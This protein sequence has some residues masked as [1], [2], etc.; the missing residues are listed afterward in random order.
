MHP[1]TPVSDSYASENGY[2][3]GL[4]TSLNKNLATVT[5]SDLPVKTG[6]FITRNS[7][8]G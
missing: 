3:A 6:P 8:F 2:Y 5:P 4:L 1:N 7:G